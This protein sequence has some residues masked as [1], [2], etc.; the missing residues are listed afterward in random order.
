[1]RVRRVVGILLALAM[2]SFGVASAAP[3]G[4]VTVLCSPNPAWCD[5]VKAEFPKAT[6][7]Q[8]DF[9]RLSSGEALARLRAERQNPSFDV[10]FGGTGDP[11][12]QAAEEGLTVE[13]KSPK[14][15]EL[16]DWAVRQAEI[17]L[18]M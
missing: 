2:M 12:L 9:V 14:L 3:A 18:R 1:M 17:E 16:H 4:K 10:W 13:Y 11:H 7:L 15:A 6:G 8:V 5:A